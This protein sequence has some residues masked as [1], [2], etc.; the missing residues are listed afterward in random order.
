MRAYPTLA[1][2]PLVITISDRVALKMERES[3]CLSMHFEVESRQGTVRS[4]SMRERRRRRSI[5][6][7]RGQHGA[8]A[9]AQRSG[10]LG[11]LREH[12]VGGIIGAALIASVTAWFQG[13]FDSVLHDVAPS[14]ADAFCALRET[15]EDHWPFAAPQV[16]SRRFTILIGTIDRDDSDHTYTRAVARAFLKRNDIDRIETCRVLRLSNVGRDA[17]ISAASTARR[18]LAQRHAD[19]LIAGELQQ[20]DKA[21]SLWFFDRDPTHAWKASTFRLDANLLKEDFAK[22]AST[23]LLGVA[24][25][26]IKPATEED[27]KYIVAVLKPIADRLRHLVEAPT[28]SFTRNQMVDL[29]NALGITSSMIGDQAGDNS[30]LAAAA[31]A[32]RAALEELTRDRVPRHWATT[33][34]NLGLALATLGERESGTAH[35]TEAVAAYRLTLEERTRDRSAA[36]LGGDAEQPRP[37]AGDAWRAGDRYGASRGGRRSVSR[38]PGGIHSRPGAARLGDDAEQPRPHASH[39]WRA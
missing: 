31:T 38:G 13:A 7:E 27:G 15:V 32:Y 19:L 26:A 20:K 8:A 39:P 17:E 1:A 25:A 30:A 9:D 18:W 29:Q 22:A 14:G 36:R 10:I 35:L 6:R 11:W 33:Q 4:R 12:I 16:T 23:Q 37:H 2:L 24:L 5:D 21:V 28:G 34:N 3:D